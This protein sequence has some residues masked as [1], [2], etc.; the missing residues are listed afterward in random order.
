MRSV[1]Q[2]WAVEV[3]PRNLAG[4]GVG[5][6]FGVTS[7]GAAV[8]PLLFGLIA[9]AWSL[10]AGFYFLAGIILFANLLVFFMPEETVKTARATAS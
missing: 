4:A 5:V 9:D 2:A 6:Q 8:S 3:T 10:Y 7:L 1:L